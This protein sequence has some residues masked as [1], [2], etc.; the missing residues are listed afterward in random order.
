MSHVKTDAEKSLADA[1]ANVEGAITCLA[2]I[3]V[4]ECDGHD[5]YMSSFRVTMRDAL[6][7]L[8]DIRDMLRS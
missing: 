1:Q 6:A 5:K 7:K 3:V 2:E 8:M 4:H